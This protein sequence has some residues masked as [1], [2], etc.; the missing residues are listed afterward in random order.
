V[1]PRFPAVA[2]AALTL[3]PL[4]F[5]APAAAS[6]GP[7]DGAPDRLI[8]AFDGDSDSGD[9][10]DALHDVHARTTQSL[11][12]LGKTDAITVADGTAA[13]AV[14]KLNDADGVAWAEVDR[15]V[16]AAFTYPQNWKWG[17]WTDLDDFFSKAEDDFTAAWNRSIGS[18]R[19][20]IAVVDTGVDF[21]IPDLRNNEVDGGWDFVSGDADPSPKLGDT[22][23]KNSHGTGV[24]GIA[25][26]SMA[27]NGANDITGGAPS[28]GIMALRALDENGSGYMS[29]VASA[30]ARAGDN[31]VRVVNASLSSTGPS[32][33][34]KDA[35]RAHPNTLYV[36]AA[37]NSSSNEDSLPP[38][39]R[40]YPC[41]LALDPDDPDNVICVAAVDSGGNLASF[42][43]YGATTVDVGGPGQKISSY[44]I[45]GT[46]KTWDGTSMA[47]PFV[48]A[49]AE[50]A[51]NQTPTVTAPQLHD[52]I[53]STARSVPALAGKTTSGGMINAD[54]L[55]TR[56]AQLPIVP[57]PTPPAPPAPPVVPT[58]PATAPPA[59]TAPSKAPALRSPQLK[60]GH[61]SRSGKRLRVTGTVTRPWKGTVTVTVCAGRDCTH[62]RARVSHGRFAAKL[63]VARGRHVKITVAAPA[64]RG[65]RAV[66]VTRSARS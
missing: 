50:L 56:V 49:A 52:A 38:D 34:V 36:V 64:V 19:A 4:S 6:Q 29:A 13:S 11:A 33:A 57:P 23:E 62:T 2:V 22:S 66:H 3:L 10:A 53:I 25:A 42:S 18:A 46:L 26:A 9:R 54:E 47:A 1:V 12:S 17:L 5:A 55:L 63:K 7:R 24:A 21:G 60:L 37:G 41:A 8:V 16:R 39:K 58:P 48:A 59:H 44:E 61:V 30:F 27:D 40:D 43:N 20:P 31:G 45:G 51:V 28:A 65:Y 32:Q 15:P 35:I 14:A